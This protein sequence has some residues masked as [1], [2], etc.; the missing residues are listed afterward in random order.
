MTNSPVLCPIFC[1]RVNFCFYCYCYCRCW[2]R[3]CYNFCVVVAVTAVVV[4]VLRPWYWTHSHRIAFLA[5]SSKF[6]GRKDRNNCCTTQLVNHKQAHTQNNARRTSMCVQSAAHK[7]EPRIS[8]QFI[9]NFEWWITK[10]L[11][12]SLFLCSFYSFCLSVHS[13]SHSHSS[14]L[15][16]FLTLILFLSFSLPPY[17]CPSRSLFSICYSLFS[18]SPI[19]RQNEPSTALNRSLLMSFKCIHDRFN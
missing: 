1:I 3:F 4:T 11:F 17:L 8:S 6:H 14:F 10:F 5:N 19:N 12:F 9:W 13:L 18:I 2:R 15:S 16:F 7:W